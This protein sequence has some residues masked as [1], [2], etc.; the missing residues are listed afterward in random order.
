MENPTFFF[1]HTEIMH[2]YLT[3]ELLHVC[4]LQ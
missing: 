3:E 1:Y 2:W 4:K